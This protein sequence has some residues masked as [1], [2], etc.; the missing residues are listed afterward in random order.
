[1]EPVFRNVAGICFAQEQVEPHFL[2]KIAWFD[3][4]F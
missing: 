2:G 1:V 3:D 4:L